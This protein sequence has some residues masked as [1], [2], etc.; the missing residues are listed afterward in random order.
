MASILIIVIFILAFCVV[1]LDFKE[2]QYLRELSS[3]V[4][5]NLLYTHNLKPKEKREIIKRE[6]LKKKNEL[7]SAQ[8][9]LNQCRGIIVIM[10]PDEKLDQV[11]NAWLKKHREIERQINRI[12]DLEYKL[13]GGS[14][15]K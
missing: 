15:L 8:H 7:S 5:K 1:Y 14:P 2:T 9:D 13:I 3:L 12:L 11:S 10:V 4:N 6:I